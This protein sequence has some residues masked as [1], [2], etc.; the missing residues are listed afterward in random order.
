[1]LRGAVVEIAYIPIAIA[2]GLFL[3][4]AFFERADNAIRMFYDIEEGYGYRDLLFPRVVVTVTS[5]AIIG[6]GMM[7]WPGSAAKV[8]LIVTGGTL[9]MLANF[10]ADYRIL[11]YGRRR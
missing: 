1:M 2:L 11:R 10:Y 4:W 8:A 6:L 5:S 7:A 9:F 3:D